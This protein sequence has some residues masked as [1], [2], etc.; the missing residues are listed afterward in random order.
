MLQWALTQYFCL[1]N[2]WKMTHIYN[3][4]SRKTGM[5]DLGNKI[6]TSRSVSRNWEETL[7]KQEGKQSWLPTLAGLNRRAHQNKLCGAHEHM[8]LP[9]QIFLPHKS[10]RWWYKCTVKIHFLVSLHLGKLNFSSP[11]DCYYKCV[12]T[13]IFLLFSSPSFL[14]YYIILYKMTWICP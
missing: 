4:H 10:K 1:L 5:K 9:I 14:L 3:R 2:I 6:I 12:G 13:I 7:E 8:N 11:S